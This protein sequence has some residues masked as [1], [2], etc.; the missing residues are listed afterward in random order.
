[1]FKSTNSNFPPMDIYTKGDCLYF[2]VALA[3]WKKDMIE[4]DINP[5]NDILTIKSKHLDFPEF[6]NCKDIKWISKKLSFRHFEVKYF[7]PPVYDKENIDAKFEDGIL[8]ISF[9]QLPSKIPQ[10]IQIK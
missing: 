3:G 6:E 4:I 2:D 8:K 5:E 9:K 1:M 10:K 7:I